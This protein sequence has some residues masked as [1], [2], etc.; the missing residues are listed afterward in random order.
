MLRCW[1]SLNPRLALQKSKTSRDDADHVADLV[2][3]LMGH[4]HDPIEPLGFRRFC[5]LS[6][7]RCDIARQ[8]DN[9]AI[10]L[11][12]NGNFR[13]LLIIGA[14]THGDPICKRSRSSVTR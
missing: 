4:A 9:A 10:W 12:V 5:L 2:A 8:D 13:D 7:K 14:M 3:Q 1:R 6:I 11:A